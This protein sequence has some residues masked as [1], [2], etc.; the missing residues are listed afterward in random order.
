MRIHKFG[1]RC[2]HVAII[3]THYDAIMKNVIAGL[4]CKEWRVR[5]STPVAVCALISGQGHRSCL[6][7]VSSKSMD[8]V[9]SSFGGYNFNFWRAMVMITSGL[10][11]RSHAQVTHTHR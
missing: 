6:H 4:Q 1:R 11:S 2:K 9:C 10:N 5:A 3:E 8:D 7:L